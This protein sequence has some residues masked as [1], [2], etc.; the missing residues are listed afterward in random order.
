VRDGF[1][2]VSEKLIADCA[3]KGIPWIMGQPYP[4]ELVEGDGIILLRIEEYD[5]VRTIYL[6]DESAFNTPPSRLGNSVGRWLGEELHVLTRGIDWPFFD[7][8]GIPQSPAVEMAEIFRLSSDG[9]RLEYELTVT[10]PETFTEPVHLDK[11]W[12]W[13]PGE[14]VR[15]YECTPL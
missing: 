7:A 4:I 12:M 3:P 8:T 10:D 14:E 1:D 13:R 5:T 15:P 9:S 6:D 11:Q 2:P